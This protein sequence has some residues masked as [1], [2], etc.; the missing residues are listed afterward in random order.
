[1]TTAQFSKARLARLREVLGGHVEHGGVPGLL[2]LV[3]RHD[4]AHVEVLGVK[5]LGAPSPMQR[6]TLFRISSMTKPIT[7]L[8]TQRNWATPTRPPVALDF[9]TAAYQ[10]IDD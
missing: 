3:S 8:F 6:D 9:A 7:L 4:E 1:M 10:A 5:A 2:A